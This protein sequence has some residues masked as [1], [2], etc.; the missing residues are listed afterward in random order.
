M[1]GS[2]GL[3]IYVD[4]ELN[5]THAFAGHGNTTSGDA[6]LGIGCILNA[7]DVPNYLTPMQA[8]SVNTWSIQLTAQQVKQNFNSQRSRFK[9]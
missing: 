2:G 4:G 6:D 3:K 9:V 1:W 5:D 7:S 8:A